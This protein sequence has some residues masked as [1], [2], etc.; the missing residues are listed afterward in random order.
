MLFFSNSLQQEHG[1]DYYNM[2]IKEKGTNNVYV[3]FKNVSLR[4]PKQCTV[5]VHVRSLEKEY[6][7]L[8]YYCDILAYIT[9]YQNNIKS[10]RAFFFVQDT[11]PLS[12]TSSS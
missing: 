10:K 6:V 8:F 11:F 2:S 3:K 1:P 5:P 9:I 12:A 7:S 4:K